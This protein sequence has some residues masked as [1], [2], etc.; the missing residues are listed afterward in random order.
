MDYEEASIRPQRFSDFIGQTQ[1]KANL[2][3]AV[4]AARGRC[5]VLDHVLLTGQPGLGKSS[6]ARILANEMGSKCHIA[7]A[8]LLRKTGD[9]TGVLLAMNPRDVLFVDEIHRLESRLEEILY[10]AMEDFRLDL[11]VG[12]RV[13]PFDLLPF[14]LIAATTH[15]GMIS[16]PL[17]ARFGIAQHL[18]YYTPA[19]LTLVVKRS[20]RILGV[21]IDE[22]G[23]AEI[24]RRGRGTPRIANCLL[25]R[26]RDH[27]QAHC[28]GRITASVVIEAADCLGIDTQGLDAMDRR[29]LQTLVSN[30]GP[31]GLNTLAASIQ[32]DESAIANVRE[33]YLLELGF[34]QRTPRGRIATPAA[35]SLLCIT[36]R[37]L[38]SL[39]S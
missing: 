33:P 17:R 8:P 10:P 31:V 7:S 5:E 21:P 24:A 36:K 35:Y 18:Q 4:R 9:L 32:E 6:L 1:V 28:E 39:F 3:T 25:R 29:L 15:A 26:A 19:E 22:S 37:P 16:E 2:E 13:V 14:T 11:I 30:G 27:A 12:E 23:A 20:A 38:V 34:V